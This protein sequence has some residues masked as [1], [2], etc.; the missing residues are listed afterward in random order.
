MFRF[1]AL[2]LALATAVPAAAQTTGPE[3][4]RL[5]YGQ[6]AA[7]ARGVSSLP[8]YVAQRR[9]FLA[10]ERIALEVV[11]IKGGTH[12]MLE[13]LDKGAVDVT[14]TA[15]PYLIEAVLKGSSAVAV[16]GAS[17]NNIYT[18]VA[19]PEIAS[20]ADL[21]GKVVGVSLAVDT[22]T[23]S[24]R[25]LLARHG[26][27]PASYRTVALVGTPARAKCL[28][29]GECAAV[30]LN[31]PED[32]DMAA[33]GFRRLGDTLEVLPDLQFS[34]LAVKREWAAAHKDHL[35]RLLKAFAGAFEFMR[36]PANRDAMTALIVDTMGTSPDTAR[37]LL[38]LY[39][40]PDKGV[41]PVR[42]EITMKGFARV[43]DLMA[44][45]GQLAAPLPSPQ[46]FVDL[47]YLRAAGV[48]QP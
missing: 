17:G 43:I 14:Y 38:A 41:F 36:A 34:V 37:R 40:E 19:K 27:P 5:R 29:E 21:K 48:A 42:G 35:V 8:L 11:P 4:T 2:G 20:F 47:D 13:A 44:E 7:S 10:R 18:L 33:R 22:I 31:Q 32:I 28:V 45:A 26:L 25:M 15:T 30:P 16:G 3:P 6:I 1:V 46:R 23:I 39:Y 9:G 12:F 24:S